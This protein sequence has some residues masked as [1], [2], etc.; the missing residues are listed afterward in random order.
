MLGT[1]SRKQEQWIE[2]LAQMVFDKIVS[3]FE[4]SGFSTPERNEPKSVL[5]TNADACKY[6]HVSGKTLKG[7]RD[8]GSLCYSKCKHP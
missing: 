1:D 5:L 4:K 7:Y 2:T 6:L 8:S 3:R